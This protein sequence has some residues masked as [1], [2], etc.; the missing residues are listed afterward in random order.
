MRDDFSTQA[1]L[2]KDGISI[3]Y[4]FL[5]ENTILLDDGEKKLLTD[6]DKIH[7]QYKDSTE[8][9]LLKDLYDAEDNN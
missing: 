7:I 4:T 9:I 8:E 6:E 1:K 5:D 3:T 2:L